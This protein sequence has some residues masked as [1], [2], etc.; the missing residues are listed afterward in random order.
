MLL[1]FPRRHRA[2]RPLWLTCTAL[3]LSTL[4]PGRLAAQAT[5]QRFD[6]AA[7]VAERSLKTLA[8]QS[9]LEV[10][11]STEVTGGV[12]TNPIK[13]E[14]SPLAAAQRML[15]GT[16][17]EATQNS[18]EGAIVVSR[19]PP[20][21]PEKNVPRAAQRVPSDRPNQNRDNAV[22]ETPAIE[23]SPFTVNS[24]ADV[25]Y[26]ANNT[27]A[28]S[29]LNTSLKDT[30]ASISVMTE[31][32][33]SDIGAFSV[34]DAMLYAGNL[35]IDQEETVSGAPTGNLMAEGFPSY[36]VRGM[37]ASVA[38][39]YFVWNVPGNTY[40]I[41]RIDESRGPNSVLFGV[42]SA[43]GI[44]NASTKQAQFGRSRQTVSL[45][46]GSFDTFRAT[47]DA[48]QPLVKN[49]LAVRLNAL[50]SQQ[51][52]SRL[53]SET[54]EQRAHFTT[55]Y[56]PFSAT[57]VRAEIERG[58]TRD[59]VTR[60]WPL[61]DAIGIW[62]ERNRPIRA[63]Q[64][65]SAPDAIARLAATTPRVTFI[66]NND[67]FVDL[68]GT[69]T[70][71]A[72]TAGRDEMITD[73]RVVDPKVNAAGNG[74][75]RDTR[76]T[77][78]SAIIEQK[79][80]GTTFVSLAFNHQQYNFV[81]HDV[82]QPGGF[83]LWGDPNQMLPSGATAMQNNPFAGRYYVEANWFR[84]QRIERFNT[85]RVTLSNEFNL[86]QWGRYRWAG[87][88]EHEASTFARGV[89]REM[90]AGRPFNPLPENAANF[91][92]R[93]TYVTEGDWKTYR[94]PEAIHHRI[95]NRVDPFTGQAL[96]SKWVQANQ[97][98]DDDRQKQ[99][100]VLVGGQA[101]W[102][103]HRLIGTIGLRRDRVK[104]EDRGTAR[105]AA[106]NE[107]VVNYDD[108]TRSTETATT[109]T[110][111]AVWHATK[112]I[113]VTY[114]QSTNSALPSNAIR[115]IPGVKPEQGEGEGRDVGLAVDLFDGKI[116]LRGGY[117]KTAGRRETDF[118]NVEAI[119]TQRNDRILDALVAARSIS[120]ADAQARR[121]ASNGDYSDRESDGWEFRVVAN[122]TN[123]WRLQANYTITDAIE[124]NILPSVRAW[125]EENIA[126]WSRF[127][128]AIPTS[129]VPSIAQEITNLRNDIAAQTEAEGR[130]AIGNRRFKG[131]VFTR[132]DFS[133]SWLRG[134]YVGGGYRYQSRML[135]GRIASTGAL[136]YAGSVVRTDALIG[137]RC[138]LPSNRGRANFQL[139]VDNVLDDTDPV[140]LRYTA[141]G[142]VRRF[143]VQ[144]PRTFRFST[145]LQF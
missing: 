42:G 141:A 81:G 68:R 29:R 87:M 36:R 31:E 110:L 117:Y 90:W 95:V 98:I 35:Q 114:N 88:A 92:W 21:P 30:A 2:W 37:K 48:N 22:D 134:L 65:A 109:R 80:P 115:V 122:P 10:V 54:K 6:V 66:E 143:T 103:E 24:S 19:K 107:I 32:F 131:N 60:P 72:S 123:N 89:G 73:R 52:T 8:L 144:E 91:V 9:G 101:S 50:W 140:I 111:G 1:S 71:V 94:I 132:Y 62:N 69:L 49:K 25:G 85:A 142:F 113:S 79:L 46:A 116:Y 56:Q 39:N 130:G 27:L 118:R 26:L 93:R 55:L 15:A 23:L 5:T 124:S 112:A 102:F 14:F 119:A 76:F 136:Q 75:Q 34:N 28:G 77:T 12:R 57:R 11:F 64:T 16:N 133:Q 128:T 121:L 18:G 63:T 78:Y 43:G 41:E 83:T 129:T 17:L 51:N 33:L 96:T 7:D 137:Y 105:D 74:A 84:R 53:Y 139:N 59:H 135:I 58:Q 20:T 104:I 108:V 61:L 125:A 86:R 82:Q 4:L 100:T 47:L 40:N 99:T 127:N 106:T 13:G 3:A 126:F 44:I 138:K 97:N 120:A 145:T 38:R 45:S 67:L 70:T